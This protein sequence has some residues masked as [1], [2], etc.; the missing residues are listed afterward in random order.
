MAIDVKTLCVAVLEIV[1]QDFEWFDSIYERLLAKYGFRNEEGLHEA[2]T[3]VLC[4]MVTDARIEAVRMHAEPP[5]VTRTLL[6]AETVENW[7]FC[8]GPLL[9]ESE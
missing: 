7:W 2:L 5:Y 8:V 1:S 4:T 6:E 9:C 3:D